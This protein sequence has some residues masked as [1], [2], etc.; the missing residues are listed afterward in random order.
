MKTITIFLTLPDGTKSRPIHIL[1]DSKGNPHMAPSSRAQG[2]PMTP[3]EA[4]QCMEYLIRSIDG[5]VVTV[6]DW[7]EPEAMS[8]SN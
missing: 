5:A 3:E 7:R 6:Q 8:L 4:E 1:R 2:D